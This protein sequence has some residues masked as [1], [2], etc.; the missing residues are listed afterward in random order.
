M[1]FQN[2]YIHKISFSENM[3]NRLGRIILRASG[4]LS[5]Q[6]SRLLCLKATWQFDRIFR[7]YLPYPMTPVTKNFQLW[8]WSFRKITLQFKFSTG[9]LPL[10]TWIMVDQELLWRQGK[11]FFIDRKVMRNAREMMEFRGGM[12]HVSFVEH[13]NITNQVVAVVVVAM[14]TTTKL[15]N[16]TQQ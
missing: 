5:T 11:C 2:G 10:H 15:N 16:W 14:K 7:I 4:D 9:V 3:K 6:I 13:L 8:T 1:I 12:A